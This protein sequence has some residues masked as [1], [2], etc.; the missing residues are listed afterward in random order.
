MALRNYLDDIADLMMDGMGDELTYR[1][2]EADEDITVIG[3]LKWKRSE[4]D[5][6]GR[7]TKTQRVPMIRVSGM[8]VDEAGESVWGDDELIGDEVVCDGAR[9][10]VQDAYRWPSGITDLWVTELGPA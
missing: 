2:A 8:P 6:F 7:Q 1:H 9:W 10:Q 4:T 3:F 5:P